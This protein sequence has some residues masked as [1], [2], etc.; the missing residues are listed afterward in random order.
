MD[1]TKLS[2]A[3]RAE[4]EKLTSSLAAIVDQDRRR[5]PRLTDGEALEVANLGSRIA[6]LEPVIPRLR[7]LLEAAASRQRELEVGKIAMILGGGA[8]PGKLADELTSMPVLISLLQSAN[9]AAL[10]ESEM[11][12]H[13]IERIK[14]AA[15]D[16]EVSHE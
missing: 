12:R 11:A 13:R 10:L 16:R 6:E 5:E 9:N 8:D 15:R 14:Q 1:A 3:A 2:K 4:Y 7:G